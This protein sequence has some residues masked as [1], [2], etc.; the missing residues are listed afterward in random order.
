MSKK[1]KKPKKLFAPFGWLPHHSSSS[2]YQ[3]TS[4]SEDSTDMLSQKY[5]GQ[6]S[7]Y[8]N[9][10]LGWQYRWLVL[11][12]KPGILNYYL[13]ESEQNGPPRGSVHLAGALICPSEEDSHTF[14][15]NATTGDIF[16]LRAIDARARQEWINKLRSVAEYHN[17]NSIK[18]IPSTESHDVTVH[19]GVFVHGDHIHSPATCESFA[20]AKQHLSNAETKCSKLTKAMD[21]LAMQGKTLNSTDPDLL[22]MKAC[23]QSV[24]NSLQE[25]VTIL[26]HTFA[27]DCGFRAT[28]ST[29]SQGKTSKSPHIKRV[30]VHTKR[31]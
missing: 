15:V 29:S 13:S 11:D 1:K 20:S 9:I 25:C 19:S 30:V 2:K 21:A 31:S 3:S 6:L 17:N 28:T 8:T 22:V 14:S 16:K 12:P 23:S 10:V 18:C 7:K 27:A 5:S 26:Q 24:V 4:I